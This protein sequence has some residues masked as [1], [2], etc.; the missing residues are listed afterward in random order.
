[1]T[2]QS[3][4]TITHKKDKLARTSVTLGIIAIITSGWIFP[5]ALLGVPAIALAIISRINTEKFYSQNITG[6]I[7]GTISIILSYV[8]FQS[9]LILLEN[10]DIFNEM[11]EILKTYYTY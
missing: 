9:A 5:G 8:S 3:N 1:M 4:N 10:P 6:L 2:E 7:L 11:A